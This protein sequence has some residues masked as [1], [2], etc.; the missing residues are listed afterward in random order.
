MGK[1]LGRRHFL[2]AAAGAGAALT[3]GRV[4]AE[5]QEQAATAPGHQP[6]VARNAP[7][8]QARLFLNDAEAAFLTA[9]IDVLLPADDVGPGGVEAGVVLYLDRQL[10]GAWGSGARMYLA[11]PW[12]EGTPQQ[13]YQLPLNPAQLFRIGMADSDRAAKDSFGKGF[14]Q[15]DAAQRNDF[16]AGLSS[17][18][19]GLSNVPGKVFFLTLQEA[20]IEGYFSDPAYGGNKGM[21][22]W[23]M[24]GFPGARGAYLDD[25]AQYRGKPFQAEPVSLAD[26]QVR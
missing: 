20:V 9:A 3:V 4:S 8:A 1:G 12:A 21:A 25:I 16:F 7:A 17:G 24:I 26:L 6:H 13:G 14:A 11:G 22:A 10:A 5:E 2:E 15:L 23:R 19:I 18:D